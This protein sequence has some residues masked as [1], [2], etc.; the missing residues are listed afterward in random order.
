MI[1]VIAMQDTQM[2]ED[3]SPIYRYNDEGKD[4]KPT[5]IPHPL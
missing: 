5:A 4:E 2:K 3:N 1:M